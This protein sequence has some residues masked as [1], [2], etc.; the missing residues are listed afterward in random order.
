[1]SLAAGVF[2]FLSDGLSIG[3]RIYPLTLP[4][5]VTLPALTYRIV[6]DEP[7]ISHST[8]QQ[9]PTFTG[10]RHAFTRVQ[11]DAYA[12]TYD[13]ADALRDE[14]VTVAVGYRGLWGE[15]EIDSVR[16]DIRL[17]DFEE[18]PALYRVIQDLIVGHRAGASS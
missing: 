9:S 3:E 2:E 7:T 6:S 10:I 15:E 16:P 17:D 14:L 1:M 4:Q 5:D 11:F 12:D 8:D 18:A 13:D